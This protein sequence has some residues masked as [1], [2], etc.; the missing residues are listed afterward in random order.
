MTTF[1]LTLLTA[2][3][4]SIASYL[5]ELA[6][7]ILCNFSSPK[8]FA[9]VVTALC[10]LYQWYKPHHTIFLFLS[11]SLK[12]PAWLPSLRT[13]STSSIENRPFSTGVGLSF[14]YK[15]EAG[16]L[17]KTSCRIPKALGI[18]SLPAGLPFC[19]P[20]SDPGSSRGISFFPITPTLY[21]KQMTPFWVR[22]L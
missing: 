15:T 9:L 12:L 7:L 6:F 19:L 13:D 14:R 4:F 18:F 2:S 8:L 3:L 1:P 16:A 5:L 22:R 21:W 10:S 11:Q 20:S 17:T